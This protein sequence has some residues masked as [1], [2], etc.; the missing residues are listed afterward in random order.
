M[1]FRGKWCALFV[2]ALGFQGICAQEN[3]A[4]ETTQNVDSLLVINNERLRNFVDMPV[5]EANRKADETL[6]IAKYFNFG[7]ITNQELTLKDDLAGDFKWESQFGVDINWGRTY[8][9]PKKPLFGMLKFGIDWSWMDISY[10]KYKDYEE[11]LTGGTGLPAPGTGGSY[12]DDEED[13]LALGIH[14]VEYGMRIGPSITVMPVFF[15]LS[16]TVQRMISH[17]SYLILKGS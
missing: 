1:A 13:E 7:Y 15:S 11:E 9:I 17:S 10:V 4:T 16:S 12:Y 6:T 2:C 14:Q 5:P 8:Y 3:V